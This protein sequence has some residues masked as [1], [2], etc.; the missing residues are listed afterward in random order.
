MDVGISIGSYHA[1]ISD[2][3]CINI[4]NVYIDVSKRIQFISIYTHIPFVSKYNHIQYASINTHIQ[5]VSM[6]TLLWKE[7][8]PWKL[9]VRC[10]FNSSMPSI[11]DVPFKSARGPNGPRPFGL[12]ARRLVVAA[13]RPR[14]PH[15]WNAS[16]PRP[17]ILS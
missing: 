12:Q 3:I 1:I 11:S 13:Y 7:R 15:S 14:T 5:Y 8:W 6:Y 9:K 4:Y 10:S 2:V 17:S 16:P